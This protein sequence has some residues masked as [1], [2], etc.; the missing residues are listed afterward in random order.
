MSH[1]STALF[2]ARRIS[3]GGRNRVAAVIAV[4][5]VA[6]AM[7]VMLITLSVA[8]GFKDAI[9]T[10][11]AGFTPDISIQPAY[12][13]ALGMQ[14][15]YMEVTPELLSAARST[16]PGARI[17]AAMRQ[18]AILKTA[19]DFSAVVLTGFNADHDF[20]FERSNITDGVWPDYIGK[21]A[22]TEKD[23]VISEPVAMRLGLK[24]GD[25]I[26][27]CFFVNDNIKARRLDVRGIFASNFGDFDR[28]VAYASMPML[29]ELCGLDSAGATAIELRGVPEEMAQLSASNLQK[30]LIDD[31]E[32][33]DKGQVPV[34]DNITRS[35]GMYL[36]W[37]Q[38]LDTNVVVI[39][40]LMCCVAAFTIVSS[41]FILILNNVPTIGVLR[42]LGASKPTVRS[43][44]VCLAMRLVGSGMIIGN[45]FAIT[46][47]WVQMTY[48][49]F[50]LD[51]DMYYLSHVPMQLWWPG[52]V[53]VNIAAAILAWLILIL[54][55]RLASSVSPSQSMRYE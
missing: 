15:Q 3:F 9:R 25:R 45:I 34:V 36:N 52:I 23:I 12:D 38:L 22:E 46:L 5:G 42:A 31:A 44:F 21:P 1:N 51:P 6:C 37:L 43:V 14:E 24:V 28:S 20:S 33:S 41:L 30:R 54:P 35:G 55:A 29:R 2:I 18:P 49:I 17:S 16:V 26:T 39:F 27:A 48:R 19:D 50:P 40:V 8:G 11:L 7:A 53:A 4:V 47:I 13:Y 32:K 10:K